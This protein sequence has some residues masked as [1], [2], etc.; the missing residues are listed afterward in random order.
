MNGSCAGGTG[1]FIDQMATL[2]NITVPELDALAAKHEKIY[3]IASRCGV[4]AKSD[5]QPLLN[6][7]ARKEDIAASILQAVVD[8]TVAGLAQGRKITGKVMFLGG[9]LF[10]I[11]SLRDRFVKTLK[12]DD[13]HA[14]FPENGDCFVAVGAAIYAGSMHPRRFEDVVG[15]LENAKNQT[16]MTRTLPPLFASKAEY[17]EQITPNKEYKLKYTID[18]EENLSTLGACYQDVVG[19][20]CFYNRAVAKFSGIYTTYIGSFAFPFDNSL[21]APGRYLM[22]FGN[23]ETIG[24]ASPVEG[25]VFNAPQIEYRIE[26]LDNNTLCIVIERPCI[27]NGATIQGLVR[28][29]LIREEKTDNN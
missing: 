12:L 6:Q 16:G 13:G 26:I 21:T 28:S 10:F 11:N 2:L 20:A 9:P 29:T 17:A 18:K 4:F 8:Q 23:V 14:I 15:L 24:K 22:I 19:R 5:I 25:L 1:S 27:E 3:S 7:G